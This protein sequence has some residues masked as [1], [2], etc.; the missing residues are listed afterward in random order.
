MP[1][2]TIPFTCMHRLGT[3]V[4][5]RWLSQQSS[6]LSGNQG[7]NYGSVPRI[8]AMLWAI[9]YHC[10]YTHDILDRHR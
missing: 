9:K 6:A 4:C 3:R 7:D 1:F 5:P 8:G 2:K 10:A